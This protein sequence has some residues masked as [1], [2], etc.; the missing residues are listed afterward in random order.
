[1]KV[2]FTAIFIVFTVFAFSAAIVGIVFAGIHRGERLRHE[3][4]RA[5]LEKG[6]PL[7]PELL[8]TPKSRRSDLQRGVILVA[9]GVG[10]SLFLLIEGESEWGVG[11]IPAS[12][13][14]GLFLSHRLGREGETPAASKG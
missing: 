6:L 5:A 14:V 9:L 3:T 4:I 8:A 13:G 1:M 2:D 11:L 10:I 7:P 12:I